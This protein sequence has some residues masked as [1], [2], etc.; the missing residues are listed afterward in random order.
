MLHYLF[1]DLL[2]LPEIL[3]DV[4][5]RLQIGLS[6]TDVTRIVIYTVLRVISYK[7]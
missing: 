3:E 6:L 1:Y 2:N 4:L 5:Y 7:L